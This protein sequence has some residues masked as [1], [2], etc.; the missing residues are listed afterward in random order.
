MNT[1]NTFWEISIISFSFHIIF[2]FQQLDLFS[3]FSSSK[4][5]IHELA[6]EFGQFAE[7]FMET[8]VQGTQLP[9]PRY[10][11]MLTQT[12]RQRKFELF[13]PSQALGAA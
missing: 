7:F 12:K 11:S 3:S 5:E 10:P 2:N 4:G 6:G 9:K 13:N 8:L 1:D